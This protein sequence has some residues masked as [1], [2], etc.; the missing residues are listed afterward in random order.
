MARATD[1]Q[2]AYLQSLGVTFHDRTLTKA[3]ASKKI[4]RAR[5]NQLLRRY[6][7]RWE[8]IDEESMDCFGAQAFQ[9]MYGD[10]DVVWIL[11][12]PDGTETTTTDAMQAI[13]A[14]GND[15]AITWLADHQIAL[16]PPP[17]LRE[18]MWQC[19]D[20]GHTWSGRKRC[21]AC[22]ATYDEIIYAIP[23]QSTQKD[24]HHGEERQIGYTGDSHC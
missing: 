3:D 1:K 12:A 6:G 15:Q 13:A 14:R 5:V 9:E 22:G 8:R 10:R 24:S 17:A 4:E 18:P 21:P 20:C 7:Y 2:K 19:L 11:H 16:Q 23:E